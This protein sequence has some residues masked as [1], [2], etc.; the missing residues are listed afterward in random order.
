MYR[1]V[2]SPSSYGISYS[3]SSYFHL[4]E[5][6]IKGL[7]DYHFSR[8]VKYCRVKHDIFSYTHYS[9]YFQ[10]LYLSV[11]SVPFSIGTS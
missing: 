7:H 2:Y 3:S 8:P 1:N 10:D 4:I 11:S 9:M 6:E 5:T